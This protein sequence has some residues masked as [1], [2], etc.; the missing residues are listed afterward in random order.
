MEAS[1]RRQYCS[2]PCRVAAYRARRN[3]KPYGTEWSVVTLGPRAQEEFAKY[4]L[5][6]FHSPPGG[7]GIS[8]RQWMNWRQERTARLTSADLLALN[9]ILP[10]IARVLRLPRA[11]KW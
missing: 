2:A 6:Q 7:S 3:G 1:A 9:R 4:M 10:D 5:E 8:H 11:D